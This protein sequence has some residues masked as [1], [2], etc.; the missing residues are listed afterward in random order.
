M[1]KVFDVGDVYFRVTFGDPGLLYPKIESF[2]YVGQNLSPEDREATW[3]FQFAD[4][5]AKF[6]SVLETEA[7]DRRMVLVPSSELSDM[8]DIA[9]LS[10]MLAQAADRRRKVRKI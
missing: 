4:S 9:A 1:G 6:G 3:Y 7:G 10:A 2:V 5:Y 8:I